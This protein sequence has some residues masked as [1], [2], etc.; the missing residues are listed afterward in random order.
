VK[1]QPSAMLATQLNALIT[2]N[3]V[4]TN[5]II[6]LDRYICS[7]L[8]VYCVLLLL[9][10]LCTMWVGLIGRCRGAAWPCVYLA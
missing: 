10:F 1:K 4:Q 5:G 3:E 8:V 2:D 7:Y 9:L 6:Q